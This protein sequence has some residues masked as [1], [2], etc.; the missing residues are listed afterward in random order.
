M[1]TIRRINTVK[2][3]FEA[4][5]PRPTALELHRWIQ[6][7]LEL[8]TEQVDMIQL[9]TQEK[10]IYIKVI[11]PNL[12]EKLTHKHEG[13]KDFK[14]ENGERT[15]V[16]ISK[17]DSVAITV[18]IFNL[19]PEVPNTLVT[20]ALNRYG[21]IKS[22]RNEQWST[23]FPL[24]VN[25]GIR[26]VKMEIKQHIPV[27]VTIAG[28]NAHITYVGQPLLCFVCHAPDHKKEDCPQRRTTL[29]INVQPRTRLLSD[30][31]VGR[32]YLHDSTSSHEEDIDKKSQ[33]EVNMEEETDTAS[34][35]ET[36]QKTSGTGKL[37]QDSIE[38]MVVV[39]EDQ[40]NAFGKNIYTDTEKLTEQTATQSEI[41]HGNVNRDQI[42][43]I[44]EDESDHPTKKL[45]HT[46]PTELPKDPRLKGCDP[47]PGCN[48][49]EK[50]VPTS[51]TNN[52][53]KISQRPHPYAIY[54]RVKENI[55]KDNMDDRSLKIGENN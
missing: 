39:E 13:I 27:S 10:S 55:K 7:T 9:N 28:Y 49:D 46:T 35:T 50:A 38:E 22:V 2:V 47:I 21:V 41:E 4:T 17:A 30:I 19:P 1:A 16:K 37:V 3:Q 34:E 12:Y 5:A 14:Y 24:P 40:P 53:T 8:N 25:N 32:S 26:A 15:A 31:V 6:Q 51:G 36:K 52:K 45:K 48:S 33:E 43:S 54:G 11:S 42:S 20:N 23:S 18:R 29:K 44:S